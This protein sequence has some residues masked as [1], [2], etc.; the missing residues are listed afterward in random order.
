MNDD[1]QVFVTLISRE[2]AADTGWL[3]G[4]L[5]LMINNLNK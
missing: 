4:Q 2:D 1:F 3:A 5:Q